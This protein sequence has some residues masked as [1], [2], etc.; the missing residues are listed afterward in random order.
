MKFKYIS[1]L[2]EEGN[3]T[4]CSILNFIE[5][6]VGSSGTKLVLYNLINFFFRACNY[7]VNYFG[8]FKIIIA[9]FLFAVE[10]IFWKYFP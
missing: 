1:M 5:L 3:S 2:N 6:P 4:F 8:S 7:P 10:F 9:F